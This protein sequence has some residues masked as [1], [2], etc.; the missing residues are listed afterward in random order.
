MRLET[1]PLLSSGKVDRSRLPAVTAAASETEYVAPRGAV[2]ELVAGLWREVLGVARVGATDD[3]F[4]LGGHSLLATQVLAR[5]RDTFQVEV[6]L[7]HLFEQPRLAEFAALVEAELSGGSVVLA[8]AI[9]RATREQA[10]P[11]SF[12]QQRLWF[13]EQLEPTAAAYHISQAIRL[14]GHL[15]IQALRKT[16]DE[17]V[18]RHEVLRTV[19]VDDDGEPAQVI[20]SSLNVE[21]PLIDLSALPDSDREAATIEECT[22]GAQLPLDLEHGP[23]F[24]LKLLKLGNEDHVLLVT[25]HHIVTDGW[26]FGV[27]VREL[28]TLYRAFVTDSPSPLPELPIQYADFAYWQR[29]QS[30]DEVNEKELDYWRRQLAGPLPVLALPADHTR[31]PQLSYRGGSI[32]FDLSPDL[33]GKLN[34]LSLTH[35]STLF[36]TLLAAFQ[37]LLHRYTGQEDIIV[38]TPIANRQR[39]EL[40]DLIGFFVN[41]LAIRV[42]L[43]G[44]PTFTELLARVRETALGAY[45]HQRTPFEK[46]VQVLQPDRDL[47]HSPVF[48]VLFALQNAPSQRLELPDLTLTQQEFP[49]SATRFELECL[50]WE[51]EGQLHGMLGYSEDL[52][53]ESTIRGMVANFEVLLEGIANAPAERINALPLLSHEKEHQLLVE[54]NETASVFARERCIHEIVEQQAEK[55]SAE[56]ALVF[57]AD[58]LS[59]RELNR[60]ANQLA[61]YL[62]K[63]GVGPDSRVGVMMDRSIEMLVSVLG[64]LKAGAAY[65]PLDPEYPQERVLFMLEDAAVQV[66]LTQRRLLDRLPETGARVVCFEEQAEAIGNESEENPQNITHSENLAYVI[67]TSGSTGTPKAVAM[68]HRALV[69]LIQWQTDHSA[70]SPRTLQ[71]ASLSFDVSFQETFST[72]CSGGTLVLVDEDTRRD[73]RQ[74]LNT[75]IEERIERLFVPYV[76]LHYLA[77]AAEAENVVPANL[78]QVLVAGE[79]LK[80]TPA[81]RSFIGKLDDAVLDN[82]YGP[83]ETHLTTALSLNGPTAEWPELPAIGRPISNTQCYVLDARM[84]LVPPGVAGELYLGGDCLARGYLHRPEVTAARFVPNPFGSQAGAR[85]Y[86]T[87]DLVRYQADGNLQFLGRSDQQVKIRGYRVELGEVEALLRRHPA[88]REAIVMAHEARAGEKALAAY[89]LA[90]PDSELVAADLRGHLMQHL[91]E[92]MT[93]A[94]FIFLPELPLT[95]SGK[96][97]RRALPKPDLTFAAAKEAYVAPRTQGEELLASLWAD[98]L[99]IDRIG[100]NDNFF[101]LGGHSL[102]ATRLMSRVRETFRVD[103]P[104]RNLFITPTIAGLAA[105]IESERNAGREIETPPMLLVSREAELP[106]SFAQERMWFLN[107]LDPHSSTYN[108]STALRLGGSLN[109]TALGQSFTE[110]LRRHEAL[111]TT[112]TNVNGRVVQVIAPEPAMALEFTDL[113]GVPDAQREAEAQRL[114]RTESQAPFNL[115]V[116]PLLRA[117]LWRLSEQDHLLLV[118]MHHIVS[119]G[120]SMSILVRELTTFYAEFASNVQPAMPALPIQYADFASWQ[121]SYLT[122]DVLEQQLTYWRRQLQQPLPLLELPADRRRPPVQTYRGAQHKLELSAETS[123]RLKEL[124]RQNGVTMFMTLLAAFKVLLLRH[125]GQEDVIVGTPI[126]GRN[127][128]EIE[129]LIGFLVNTLVLRTSLS[130]NPSFSELL[131]RVREVTLEAYHHQDL[132]FEKLVDALQVP[133]DPGHTPLFQV[134]FAFQNVLPGQINVQGLDV[135]AIELPDETAKFDLLL[136][137]SESGEQTVATIVYNTDLFEPATIERFADH[138]VSVIDAAVAD[139]SS[140]LSE[141]NLLAGEEQRQLLEWGRNIVEFPRDKSI[142][143]VFE[144]QAALNP[145]AIAVEFQNTRLTYR[146]L[147]EKANQLAHYLIELGV[148]PDTLVGLCVERSVELIAGVIGILKAG[149]AYVP[150][151]PAYPQERLSAMFDE[152][153]P[154]VLLT[155]DALLSKLPENTARVVFVDSDTARIARESNANP[156]RSNLSSNNLAYVMYTSGSTGRPK[157][158]SLTQRNIIRFCKNTNW[159]PLTADQTFLQLAPMSFDASTLEIWPCLLNGARLVVMPPQPPSLEELAAVLAQRQVTILW[160]TAGLFHQMADYHPGALGSLKY[161]M[162]G[163]DVLSPDHVRRVLQAAHTMRLLNGYGPTECT[164]FTSTHL[165]SNA[166]EVDDPVSIGKPIA[167]TEIYLL[168]QRLQLVPLGSSGELYVGGD[169]VGRCY[170]Q[171]PD[172]TAERF[173]PNP[174]SSEPGARLYRT[175]DMARFR[176]DG[177][178]E[179]QGRR[180]YQVKVRGFRIELGDIELAC[181]MHPAVKE[182]VVLVRGEHAEDKQL[183]AYLAADTSI[184]KSELRVYLK[185]KLPDYMVPSAFVILDEF[186]L[187]PNG[188]IDRRALPLPGD[189]DEEER[190]EIAPRTPVEDMLANIWADVFD[191]KAVGPHDDFFELGGHSLLATQV[192][193]RIRNAFALELP[194]RELFVNPTVAG[195]AQVID[196]ALKEDH[197]VVGPPLERVPRDQD[198]PL[199]FAQQRLWFLDQF[200][201]NNVAYHLP[202]AVRLQGFLDIPAL[203]QSLSEVVR[204]HEVLRTVFKL[205][206]N[207]GPVQHA[208]PE[209]ELA[210]SV[211]DLSDIDAEARERE[212]KQVCL[213]ALKRPFDLA[214]G[215]LMRAGLIKLADDEYVLQLVMHHI[216]GDAWSLEIFLREV[217]QLYQAFRA[218]QPAPLAE[219]PVQYADYAHWQRE[220]LQGE[221]FAKL[222]AYW[223]PRLEG[224]PA[225]LELPSDRPRPAVQSSRGD[226]H[227]F[228]IGPELTKDLKKLSRREGATIFMTL[229]AAFQAL[230][231]RYTGVTD[232]VVGADVNNRTRLE[233]EALIGFFI[234]MLVLRTDLSGNPTFPEL[235]ARVRQTALGAYAHQ[236]MPL[237][238]LVEELQP[239]RNLSYSPLFQVVFNFNNS[240][241]QPPQLPELQLSQLPLDFTEVKFD[242]SL[243]MWDGAES[244]TGM[245]TYSTDLFDA[246]RIH[247][248][249]EHFVTLLQNIVAQPEQRLNALEYLTEAEREAQAV[250]KRKLKNANFQKFKGLRPQAS[251]HSSVNL[252][253]A[254]LLHPG[255]L[256]PLVVRPD[257]EDVDLA[258]W[259]K[260]NPQF[261]ET[262]LAKHGALL[263]RDFGVTSMSE[264]RKFTTAISPEL[265]DYSE[266]SSPR[267]HLQDRIYTSTEYPADQWIQLHNEMSYAHTWPRRVYFYC[268]QP[269]Q[270]G[271]ETPIAF[272]RKVFELLDAKIRERFIQRKVM[273]VRNF[274]D[275]LDL[276]WQH[277]FHTD[278]KDEVAAYCRAANVEFEWNNGRLKTR[279]VRQAVIKHPET[280]E[281]VWFNQAHAFHASTL[282]AQIREFLLSEKTEDE[283]PRNAYYGDGSAIESSVIAEIREA[284][285][286]AAITFPW[287]PGDILMIDNMRVAHGRAPFAGPRKILVAMS[288]SVTNLEVDTNGD[289]Y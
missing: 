78:R 161:L 101:D 261:I 173:V 274:G 32:T 67:Y 263:F 194:L 90:A 20:H 202:V 65:L 138:F 222:L 156:D 284:Y 179:F 70:A 3:F 255:E 276:P 204:R 64:T 7:R 180:D 29:H 62:R 175:G 233:T 125:T 176:N 264:F 239:E 42:D 38:G 37:T 36:M 49:G 14:T 178:L 114:L 220:W 226:R 104:L 35:R 98:V 11:L 81:I 271:G 112:F 107:Q 92:H 74:L 15:N 122:G 225:L 265:L 285:R 219:L 72:W 190:T 13:I 244:L 150:F 5:V 2:E 203:Q 268:E 160:L 229:L 18:R 16:F 281:T 174:F 110:L 52:F 146:Q 208:L 277:V 214:V 252:V 135:S 27:L 287:K 217:V 144:E 283:F 191:Q 127:R 216:V 235:L 228:T 115:A 1:L 272:S 121:K 209:N 128:P 134:M 61:H 59:Y 24:R 186:P 50:M 170:F 241:P 165:M 236:E 45:A 132:P 47:S 212:T 43:G 48:Q 247:R 133:R 79:Q 93:P 124:S 196:S 46:L 151:D 31:P 182:A 143:E 105:Q 172:L 200:E 195:L 12:A 282:N 137:A 51:H 253:Q 142:A 207:G 257:G 86:R 83:S 254:E 289:L 259:A 6:P 240:A 249:H 75:L 213:A 106:L 22:A 55:T 23:L 76:A 267:T 198:L 201:P 187:M 116:G 53:G 113:S 158:V 41:T 185:D 256:L 237:E 63:L 28:S 177:T 218:D 258:G 141:L 136:L 199:S 19:F 39:V 89:V 30:Q 57:G 205:N 278:D 273:Y 88:V 148:G 26:S 126:A 262:Q 100:V 91:P 266:P 286:Q 215:P 73:S 25:M 54:W 164:V 242:L 163:G 58:S 188:K 210:L 145:D 149:G 71:F 34:R 184:P 99:G 250:A 211:I 234:N 227:T 230:L 248:M 245:W 123:E 206:S 153:Q 33:T 119:D 251:K 77:Q 131:H 118:T 197:G 130:G 109:A 167:N 243:F 44:A 85:L 183:V 95:P 139:P 221:A 269:A 260:D 140:P 232:I 246:D 129:G 97:N 279:Q 270:Q 84:Q 4:E 96:L 189:S 108:M 87:G 21:L 275:G 94:A 159:A 238:K 120:W 8:P 162:A 224:A 192:I 152:A 154:K 103:L 168:D 223:K 82:H 147:N 231:F 193:T 56:V 102:I 9:E 60:R 166:D 155:Q 171:R 68:P 80:I 117:H 10:L 69:N 169:G 157:G 17:I 66:L 288:G 280:G 40:E 181:A 111:R